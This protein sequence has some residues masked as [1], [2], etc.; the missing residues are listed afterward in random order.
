MDLFWIFHGGAFHLEPP[1]YHHTFL[2][3]DALPRITSSKPLLYYIAGLLH[4]YFEYLPSLFG[5]SYQSDAITTW[6][7]PMAALQAVWGGTEESPTPKDESRPPCFLELGEAARLLRLTISSTAAPDGSQPL[8][9][10]L[11]SA[12]RLELWH[13][14]WTRLPS[15]AQ[16]AGRATW[17]ALGSLP[18]YQEEEPNDTFFVHLHRWRQRQARSLVEDGDA[19]QATF[20]NAVINGPSHS[21]SL[22]VRRVLR[23]LTYEEL[24]HT[25]RARLHHATTTTQGQGPVL[26]FRRPFLGSEHVTLTTWHPRAVQLAICNARSFDTLATLLRVWERHHLHEVPVQH[27][28][29]VLLDASPQEA[30]GHYYALAQKLRCRHDIFWL[31]RY[32]M[33]SVPTREDL[34]AL[35]DWASKFS[36]ALVL[37]TSGAWT[38]PWIV[39]QT[40][41]LT[42]DKH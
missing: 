19:S 12:A 27:L 35:K 23:E 38:L 3:Q 25:V 30:P 14:L 6:A 9:L 7:C 32:T 13:D 28:G 16:E 33:S 8:F 4:L 18:Y 24:Y 5:T 40:L 22:S 20:E 36:Y 39:G 37:E 42:N 26:V 34:Q 41:S 10:D 2:Q 29:M 15:E 21:W 17:Q 31:L 1:A 11:R